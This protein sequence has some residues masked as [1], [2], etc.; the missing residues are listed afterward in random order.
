[1]RLS[2]DSVLCDP[3]CVVKH[4]SPLLATSKAQQLLFRIVDSLLLPHHLTQQDKA[5]RDTLPLYLQVRTGTYCT[6]GENANRNQNPVIAHLSVI[7]SDAPLLTLLSFSSCRVCRWLPACLS[8]RV[9]T[10]SSSSALLLAD[11]WTISCP[12]HLPWASSPTTRCFWVPARPTRS[13]RGRRWGGPSW[14]CCGMSPQLEWANHVAL[15]WTSHPHRILIANTNFQQINM[16]VRDAESYSK[17][18]LLTSTA[19]TSCRWK[20]TPLRLAW[21]Q[22]R[23]SCWSF[24]DEIMTQTPPSSLCPSPRCFAV[25]CSSTNHRV[26]DTKTIY[27]VLQ[28]PDQP[29]LSRIVRTILCDV[30]PVLSLSKLSKW[31]EVVACLC[32]RASYFQVI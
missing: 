11:I 1:M 9:P 26:R 12:P 17:A 22:S 24:S 28:S 27:C 23:C 25:W 10:W 32:D 15:T 4:W 19:R 20:A 13:P 3:G 8:L 31:P 18:P 21:R 7:G 6:L 29:F 16:W 14:R 5:L 2:S 30:T